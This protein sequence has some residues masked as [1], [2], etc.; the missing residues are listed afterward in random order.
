MMGADPDIAAV[1]ATLAG[2]DEAFEGLVLRYQRPILLLI[3]RMCGNPGEAPDIAQRVFLKAYTKLHTFR[4]RSAFK[5]W[6]YSI[7]MNLCRNEL[8]RRKRLGHTVQVEESNPGVEPVVESGLIGSQR[9]RLLA[10]GV[11]LLPPKQKSVLVLRVYQE[12]SFLEIAKVLGISENSAK[13]NY[14][15][16][17]R[18]LQQEL[19]ER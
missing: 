4:R 6:L 1:D 14:H 17:V 15:H 16:A 18:R 3:L 8:R 9:K 10:A 19:S 5:T 13:V 11:E 7:A 12:M 2:D